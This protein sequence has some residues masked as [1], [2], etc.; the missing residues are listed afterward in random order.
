MIIGTVGGVLA[1][2]V[3]G[4][5]AWTLSGVGIGG[6]ASFV[7]GAW[8][9]KAWLAFKFQRTAEGVPSAPHLQSPSHRSG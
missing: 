4:V 2:I 7:A 3:I 5:L 8:F 6:V 9:R 1:V